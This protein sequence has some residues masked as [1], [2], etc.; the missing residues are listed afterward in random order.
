MNRATTASTTLVNMNA[1]P[2]PLQ[3]S[4]APTISATT[5]T[6]NGC[7]NLTVTPPGGNTDTIDIQATVAT[8]EVQ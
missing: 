6:T 3:V 2:T 8:T 5:D 1:T 4:F 7:L